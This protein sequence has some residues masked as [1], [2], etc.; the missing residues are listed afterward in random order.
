MLRESYLLNGPERL[1]DAELLA[2]LLEIIRQLLTIITARL[3]SQRL[4]ARVLLA[5]VFA[6]IR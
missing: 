1:G 3:R 4:L 5:I 6:V 2:L